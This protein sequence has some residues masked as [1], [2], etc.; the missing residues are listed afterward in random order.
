MS[1]SFLITVHNE[2]TEL[3]RLFKQIANFIVTNSTLDEIVVVD[4]FSTDPSTIDVLN[5]IRTCPFA[6]VLQHSLD[7][8]FGAHK[9][10]GTEQCTKD[11]V[12]QLDADEYLAPTLLENLHEI[13]E[14]N[15]QAELFWLPR[16]NIVRG[17]TVEDIS[18]PAT[19]KRCGEDVQRMSTVDLVEK[20]L[21]DKQVENIKEHIYVLERI[22]K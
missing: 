9:Q 5:D 12:C 2:A 15:S 11:F 13:L 16:V 8:D 20:Y 4:D 17:I 3:K 7:G 6:R 1:I 10:W 22:M 18:K 14:I 21:K 19:I